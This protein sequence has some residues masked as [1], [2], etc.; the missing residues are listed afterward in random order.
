MASPRKVKQA[1]HHRQWVHGAGWLSKFCNELHSPVK[2]LI[3][4]NP[5]AVV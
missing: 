1:R 5:D 4:D 3:R 2:T